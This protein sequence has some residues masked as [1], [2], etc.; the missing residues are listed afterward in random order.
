MSTSPTDTLPGSVYRDRISGPATEP[1]LRAT[2]PDAES[3]TVAARPGPDDSAAAAVAAAGLGVYD[4]DLVS[5]ATTWSTRA[6][7]IFGGFEA[8][9]TAV[10]LRARVHPLDWPKLYAARQE[11]ERH[12]A[13]ARNGFS[14]ADRAAGR[15]PDPLATE[16]RHRVILASGEIRWVRAAGEY[17]FAA[18]GTAFRSV[19]ILQDVTQETVDRERLAEESER[20]RLALAAAEL[21]T[22]DLDPRHETVRWDEQTRR[23]FGLPADDPDV[24]P[25]ASAVE[26][27][28]PDDRDRVRE[29]FES[30]LAPGG[31]GRLCVEHRIVWPDG[32]VRRV[33]A[34]GTVVFEEGFGGRHPVRTVGTVEDVTDRRPSA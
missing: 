14:E 33:I 7:E 16:L 6:L 18:D 20:R 10:Q 32:A 26:R 3:A 29:V 2:P 30:S 21:G 22:F 23:I 5:G 1:D 25:L 11:A 12:A 27:I 31:D 15:T 13:A 8:P 4:F 24:R 28:F 19:G 17:Q 34:R 9:P